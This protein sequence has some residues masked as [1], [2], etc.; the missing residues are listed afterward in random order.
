MEHGIQVVS[1]NCEK[2]GRDTKKSIDEF[3]GILMV[4]FVNIAKPNF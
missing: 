4:N 1:S 2:I 3:T